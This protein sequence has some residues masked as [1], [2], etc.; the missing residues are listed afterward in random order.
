MKNRS[1]APGLPGGVMG[2]LF[3]RIFGRFLLI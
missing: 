3:V 1:H 2:G